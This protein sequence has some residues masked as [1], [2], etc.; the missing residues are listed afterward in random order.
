[1]T[2]L[3]SSMPSGKAVDSARVG[4]RVWVYGAQSYRPFGTAA[5]LTV[6]P[7]EQA[8]ELPDEVS[9]E[10]G[11]CLGIPGITAHR[12]VFADGPVSGKTV[13]VQGVLGAVGSL[14]TQLAH[15]GGATVIGTVTRERDLEAGQPSR[16]ARCRAR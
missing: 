10:L 1:M 5:Q 15:W 14:A 16:H 11:A 13:L 6:V 2:D 8:V 12:A 4:R 9:D 3:V 7:A